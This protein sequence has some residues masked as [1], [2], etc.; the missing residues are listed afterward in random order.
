MTLTLMTYRTDNR[1]VANRREL[2]VVQGDILTLNTELA[3]VK[4]ELFLLR[5]QNQK[6][7]T[8]VQTNQSETEGTRGLQTFAPHFP[9]SEPLWK[10][11]CNKRKY[12]A[13]DN[14][15]DNTADMGRR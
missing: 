8:D 11:H 10:G 1:E 6:Q 5:A 15:L 14:E 13:V 3:T 12:Q 7:A 2:D 4:G 9:P